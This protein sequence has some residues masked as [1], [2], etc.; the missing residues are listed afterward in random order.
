MS[1]WDLICIIRWLPNGSASARHKFPDTWWQTP[2]VQVSATVYD[3]VMLG[4]WQ[5]AG[6]PDAAQPEPLLAR[7][8]T[9]PVA[10]KPAKSSTQ[11]RDD[12]AQLRAE[13]RA[14]RARSA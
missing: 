2:D 1:W 9:K 3:A 13:R 10:P 5:R 6:N 8:N 12:L 4:N 7:V 14:E 11:V